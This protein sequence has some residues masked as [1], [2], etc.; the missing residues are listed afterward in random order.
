M[1]H[2]RVLVVDDEESMRKVVS[3]A[4]EQAGYEVAV[5]V[6]A[7]EANDVMCE[8]DPDLVVLDVMLP[9]ESGLEFCRRLRQDSHVP[10][11]ML[12]ARSEEVDR[13]LGLEFGADDYIVKPFSPRELV[14]RVKA[15]LRRVDMAGE[16]ETS[17]LK[18]GE[19]RIDLDSHQAFMSEEAVHLTTSEFQILTLLA[20]HP[21]KVFTRQAIMDSLWG[22]G[23]VGDERAVDVHVHNL[24]E[25]LE[26]D[27]RNPEYIL[28]VRGLG[29]RLNE[30]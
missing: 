28:T 17:E 27:P 12:S 20:R 18:I 2:R 16:T 5:S 4:L 26:P 10:I 14:S 6:D 8:F 30:A 23:F 25:K 21:G 29:Y 3:Y 7:E 11:I 24:R 1:E 15:H 13:V 22:G 19:L 9:G